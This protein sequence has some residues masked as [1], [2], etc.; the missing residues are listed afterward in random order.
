MVQAA[1]VEMIKETSKALAE[2]ASSI[3]EMKWSST[4]GKHLAMGTEAAN[5]V[6]AL[7]PAENSTLLDVLISA[8]TTSLLTEVVRCTNPIIAEVDELS[9]LV[10]FKRP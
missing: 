3:R 10:E 8:T 6:K 7:V 4:T 9:R 2:L 5:R 1:C